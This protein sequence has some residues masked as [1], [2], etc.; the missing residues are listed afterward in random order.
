MIT[1]GVGI[2]VWAPGSDDTNAQA[3]VNQLRDITQ[4]A[5][6]ER[7]ADRWLLQALEDLVAKFDWP[8]SKEIVKEDFYDGE[9]QSAPAWEVVSGQFWLMLPLDLDPV[10]KLLPRHNQQD[11]RSLR[12]SRTMMSV[13]QYLG[14]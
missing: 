5:R 9:Y 8:W 7:A 13:R 3:L 11:K 10:L 14:L 1:S 4:R 12:M 2:A 6:K